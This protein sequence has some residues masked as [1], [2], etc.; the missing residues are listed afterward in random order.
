MSVSTIKKAFETSLISMVGGLGK[1]NTA[2]EGTGFEPKGDTPYQKVCLLPL[3]PENPTLGDDYYREIGVF[4]IMLMYPKDK[5]TGAIQ[6]QAE[7]IQKHF[8]RG[9]TLI[10]DDKVIIINRTPSI[11]SVNLNNA[12]LEV[13]VRISYYCEI[14]NP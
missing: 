3:N 9:T 2:F 1:N 6:E 11:S 10:K 13:T 14:F 12:R 8:K 5:G 4:Q 7:L